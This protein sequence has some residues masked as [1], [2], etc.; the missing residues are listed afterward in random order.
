MKKEEEKM[1]ELFFSFCSKKHKK[2]KKNH[3]N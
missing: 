1:A 3:R 2:N